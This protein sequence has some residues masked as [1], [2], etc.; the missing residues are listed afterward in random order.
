[1]TDK[2]GKPGP[3]SNA[4]PWLT[5]PA[6]DYEGHMSS[7][8]VAQL[9]FLR[10]VFREQLTDLEPQA[11]AVLGCTTGNGFE[12]IDPS[13]TSRVLGVDINPAY[14]RIAADRFADRLPGLEL[15][16][17]D[18]AHLELPPASFDLVHCA[19]ILEY[20]D[21]AV[22]LPGAA[23]ALRDGGALVAVLQLATASGDK[24]SNTPYVSL[25]RLE[26]TMRL[27]DPRQLSQIATAVGL[28]EARSDRRTLD[29]GK[30]FWVGRFIRSANAD[31][32]S[33]A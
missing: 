15:A 29:S 32:S 2:Q 3:F 25:R 19:L 7:P 28:C 18:V 14:L 5:I 12:C 6:A 17:A 20:V 33:K 10:A 8:G 30:S 16:C 23:T 31:L 24:V 11:I 22:V 9:Q 1:M 4:N 13:V 26:P 21:P 27:V